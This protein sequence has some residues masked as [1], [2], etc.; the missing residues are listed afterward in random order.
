MMHGQRIS[1]FRPETECPGAQPR[2]RPSSRRPKGAG[3][4]RAFQQRSGGRSI[5]IGIGP[6]GREDGGEVSDRGGKRVPGLH[7]RGD[8][9][10]FGQGGQ[11]RKRHGAP[12]VPADREE[13]HWQKRRTELVKEHSSEF[14]GQEVDLV[15]GGRRQTELYVTGRAPEPDDANY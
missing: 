5:P 7:R 15:R 12:H 3:A 14:G 8:S 13:A 9:G 6:L 2:T 4:P 10:I 1:L 11:Q